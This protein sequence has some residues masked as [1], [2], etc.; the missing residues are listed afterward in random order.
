MGTANCRAVA[1]G[2][3]L[4]SVWACNG[5]DNIATGRARQSA[6]TTTSSNPS[7][8]MNV[9]GCL[10]Q[11]ENGTFIL[12][13]L[14]RPTTPDA[15]N[16][17][18]VEREELAA[19]EHSYR[20]DGPRG[21]DLKQLVGQQVRVQGRIVKRSDL[22]GGTGLTGTSGNETESK[23]AEAVAGGTRAVKQHDLAKVRA[24]SVQQTGKACGS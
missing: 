21:T 1:V 17:A 15:L 19:A 18:V 23:Q 6:S 13:E 11:E 10:Q 5:R 4:L 9:T 16:P 7:A 22:V 20:L 2:V 24:V 14:N 12:T 3:A 8:D